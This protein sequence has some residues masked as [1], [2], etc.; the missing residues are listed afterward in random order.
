MSEDEGRPTPPE[1]QPGD[2]PPPPPPGP[3][4]NPQSAYPVGEPGAPSPYGPAPQQFPVYVLPDHPKATSALVVGIVALAG[5][6]L[7]GLP[8][9]ASPV[10]WVLGAQ[11]RREIRNAPQHW[12]GESKATAGMVLGIIG[13]ALLL[14]AVVLIVV[15]VLIAVS[16]PNAFES[17]TGV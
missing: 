17:D 14:L 3:Q 4:F 9:L 1:G 11:A 12:G 8:I 10:A 15:I 7:C 16:D 13:T 2:A 6:F 5:T